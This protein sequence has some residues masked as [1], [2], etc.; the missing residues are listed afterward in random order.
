MNSFRVCAF[1]FG[2][3]FEDSLSAAVFA[4]VYAALH[5]HERVDV[6]RLLPVADPRSAA[7]IVTGPNGEPPV[8]GS[9]MPFSV[10]VRCTPVGRM[11]TVIGEPTFRSWPFA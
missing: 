6:L 11:V 1:A 8:G 10:N 7:E 4:S 5:L 2:N 3:A 9:K